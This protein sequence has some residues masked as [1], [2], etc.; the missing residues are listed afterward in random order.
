MSTPTSTPTSTRTLETPPRVLP[1]YIRAAAPLIPG[2]SLLPFLPGGGGQ[3]PSMRLQLREAR[4]EPDRLAAYSR[5]CGFT[6]GA[7]LPPTYPHVLAFPLHMALMADHAFPFGAVGVLHVANRIVQHRAIDALEPLAISAELTSLQPHPRGA[8][9]SFVSEASVDGELVW[10]ETST[11]LRLGARAPDGGRGRESEPGASS[12]GPGEGDGVGRGHPPSPV[13]RWR[14]RADLGRRYAAVS[15]DCNPIHLHP[16]ASR[17][18]GFASPIAHG[19]WTKAR[20]LAHLQP[21]LPD[22]FAVEV[23]FK[24]PVVLPSS[25]ELSVAFDGDAVRFLLSEP[26]REIVHLRGF[27]DEPARM[28]QADGGL[29]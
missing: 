5:V 14:I 18:L 9:F 20:C 4:A 17:A 13:A 26:K 27:V 10:R 24:K 28:A 3:T 25:V 8:T 11:M 15:G 1:L 23:R 12:L 22:A 19:M 29:G 2:A 7:H 6:L 21:R 16:L